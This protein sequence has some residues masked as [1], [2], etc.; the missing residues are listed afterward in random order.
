[1]IHCLTI[2]AYIGSTPVYCSEFP[3]TL[4]AHFRPS[5]IACALGSPT[6]ENIESALEHLYASGY[7]SCG[8]PET[9]SHVLIDCVQYA[10]QRQERNSSLLQLGNRPLSVEK[11]LGSWDLAE[12]F[13]KTTKALDKFLL[14]VGR[15]GI[16]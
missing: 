6:Q 8:D 13:S 12:D 16:L 3:P 11:K 10:D 4:A 14:D 15:V 5:F 7:L 1:M 2:L 9:I